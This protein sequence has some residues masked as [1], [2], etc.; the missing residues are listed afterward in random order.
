[1]SRDDWNWSG[2]HDKSDI[3]FPTT[4]GVAV[5]TNA[6]G[7]VVIRQQGEMGDDD[8]VIIVPRMH[9]FELAKALREAIAPDL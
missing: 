1:M 5:Y 4:R 7:D 3:V 8:A 6:V 9:I 2:E